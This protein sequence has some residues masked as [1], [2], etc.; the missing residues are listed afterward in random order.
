MDPIHDCKHKVWS[1]AYAFRG[2][3]LRDV[4]VHAIQLLPLLRLKAGATVAMDVENGRLIVEPQPHPRYTLAELLSAS[5]YSQPQPPEE[6]EWV[7]APAVGG[8]LL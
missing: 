1:A 8:E 2:R 6:R 4:V 3:P 7:D 5:D